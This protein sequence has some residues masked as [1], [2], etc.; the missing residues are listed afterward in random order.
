M[1]TQ[2]YLYRFGLLIVWIGM[3]GM[4]VSIF[5]GFND[6]HWKLE[7][8]LFGVQSEYYPEL[9]YLIV[10]MPLYFIFLFAGASVAIIYRK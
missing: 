1:T 9:F 8:Y 2:R 7:K 5:G 6:Y 10:I 3:T 4:I